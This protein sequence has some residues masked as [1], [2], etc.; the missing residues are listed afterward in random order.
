MK[1]LLLLFFILTS[2]SSISQNLT[3]SEL[4]ALK[5]IEPI[6][7][8]EFL[9][10]KKWEFIGAESPD[11]DHGELGVIQFALEKDIYSNKAKA[12]IRY[13]YSDVNI[14]KRISIQFHTK[15]KYLE[16]LDAVKKFNPS[17]HD[18]TISGNSITKVYRGKTTTFEF[19]ISKNSDSFGSVSEIFNL[20]IVSNEDYDLNF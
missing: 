1:R 9:S 18:S 10:K 6:G 14:I 17:L 4:I 16:Y 20:M 3:L 8:E 7:L 12:F 11:Y 2:S 19:E 5:S 15:V 13:Y